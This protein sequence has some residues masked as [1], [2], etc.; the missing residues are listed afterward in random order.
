MYVDKPLSGIKA[1]Q[2]LSRLNRAHPQKHDCFVLDFQNNSHAI[3]LAFHY[4]WDRCCGSCETIG[5]LAAVP[6]SNTRASNVAY[7]QPIRTA[8]EP[9]A[10]YEDAAIANYPD[11]RFTLRNGDTGD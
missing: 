2:T 1:A 6:L 7:K 10:T 3:T 9:Q 11:Q 5:T 4:L 8:D